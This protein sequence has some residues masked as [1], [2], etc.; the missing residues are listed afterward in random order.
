MK[1]PAALAAL[2]AALVLLA[3][4]AAQTRNPVRP[5]PSYVPGPIAISRVRFDIRQGR[6]MVTTDLT[7]PAGSALHEDLDVHVGF[8]APG[9]PTAFDAQLLPTPKGYLVAPIDHKG[10]RLQ[11][12][13]APRA[14][15]HVGL[16]VGRAELAGATVTLPASMLTQKLALSGQATLRLREVRELPAPLSDGTRE[17]LARLASS[18]GRPLVLGLI[19]LA[20]DEPIARVEAHFCGV[21]SSS[22]PLFVAAAGNTRGAIAPPL[23]QRGAR[24]DLCI[25]FGPAA[26]AHHGD[27]EA[28]SSRGAH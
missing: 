28:R 6:A 22:P 18:K 15:A 19:E 21:E 12:V 14:P 9:M 17:L 27:T 4:L 25:R 26:E 2:A 3:P 24:D 5:A 7:I 20:S 1:G 13:R 8:G 16:N 11:T 10:D 23:A